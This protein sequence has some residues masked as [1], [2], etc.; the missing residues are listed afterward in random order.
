LIV[1][2]KSIWAWKAGFIVPIP[3]SASCISW[4]FVIRQWE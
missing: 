3:G 1:E 4:F 2:D